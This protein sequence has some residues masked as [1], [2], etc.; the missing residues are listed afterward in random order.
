MARVG[1]IGTGEIA[2]AL[3]RGLAGRGH[4]IVVSERGAETAAALKAE[5]AELSV[6][7]N[8]DVIDSADIVFLCLKKPVAE[9][10]LAPL[11]F[12]AG[13]RIIS[14]MAAVD[15][16]TLARLCAPAREISITIPLPFIRAGGCPL[17]VFPE[18]A[19]LAELLGDRNPIIPLG[20]E[21]AIPP[22]FAA[23]AMCSS[24]FDHLKTGAEWLAGLTGD[25]AGAEAYL[26]ALIGGYLAETPLDGKDRL[27][28]V[29]ESLDTEGGLNTTLREHMRARGA[30]A[31][32]VDGLDG[33]RER[34]DLPPKA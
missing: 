17:P 10:A 33:F 34:L 16:S 12:R 21:A 29:L 5:I 26:V 13:P 11:R 23:S 24:A 28:A 2:A 20:S 25:K 6:A 4:E 30:N 27:A 1:F 18:S 14:V 7:A 3:A 32:L 15:L 8:Q 31:A 9:A 22:H 19:A